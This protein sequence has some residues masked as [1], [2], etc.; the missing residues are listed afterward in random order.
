MKLCKNKQIK[1]AYARYKVSNITSIYGA[2]EKPSEE[3]V[4]VY[5]IWIN[6]IIDKFDD[7]IFTLRIIG[8]NCMQFSLGFI[9]KDEQGIENFA[10]ITK[11]ND[12]YCPLSELK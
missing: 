6:R 11:D 8:H 7:A 9:F 2:Y 12:R 1:D 3:K 4:R 10:Y 5:R